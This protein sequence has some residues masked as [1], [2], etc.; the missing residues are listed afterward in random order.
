MFKISL[1]CKCGATLKA[2]GTEIFVGNQARIFFKEHRKCIEPNYTLGDS[3][4]L[5]GEWCK[6]EKLNT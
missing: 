4:L 2:E 3:I 1:K 6:I 5:D